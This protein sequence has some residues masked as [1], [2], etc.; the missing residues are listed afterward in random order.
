V[1]LA[2]EAADA[3]LQT[4]GVVLHHHSGDLEPQHLPH[5]PAELGHH[6][7]PGVPQDRGPQLLLGVERRRRRQ[8]LRLGP[9]EASPANDEDLGNGVGEEGGATGQG[10]A[11]LLDDEGELRDG[12]PA[13]PGQR[14]AERPLR[15]ALDE[16]PGPA[17]ADQ[18]GATGEG[19]RLELL[20]DEGPELAGEKGGATLGV[21][22]GGIG[23]DF[24]LRSP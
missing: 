17:P 19:A 7:A 5:Q 6:V 21:D 18:G 20:P 15:V 24:F 14:R 10:A 4:G 1:G 22:A 12:V 2:V 8:R 3:D 23:Y 9:L 11:G 16:D 13:G